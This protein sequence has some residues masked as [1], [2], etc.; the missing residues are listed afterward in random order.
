[1]AQNVYT[2]RQRAQ[3]FL[4]NNIDTILSR[5]GRNSQFPGETS[6]TPVTPIGPPS[7]AITR[8]VGDDRTKLGTLKSATKNVVT[9]LP[10]AQTIVSSFSPSKYLDMFD[11]V[12]ADDLNDLTP[13]VTLYKVYPDDAHSQG[14][15]VELSTEWLKDAFE[16]TLYKV[17]LAEYKAGQRSATDWQKHFG[18]VGDLP[19]VGITG[20]TIKKLG[21]NPAE[22]DSNIQVSLTIET[23]NLNN[24]FYRYAPADLPGSPSEKVRDLIMKN[25]VAWIDL[26]KLNPSRANT[27]SKCEQVYN[28]DD[29]RIKLKI[30]Y[31]NTAASEDDGC[32][33]K[34]KAASLSDK[35]FLKELEERKQDPDLWNTTPGAIASDDLKDEAIKNAAGKT[36]DYCED[37]RKILNNH[38]ETFYL[39]LKNHDLVIDT[40]LSV[41]LTIDFIGYGEAAQRTGKADLLHNPIL[42]RK[43]EIVTGEIEAINRRL[44]NYPGKSMDQ[45]EAE[46]EEAN[47]SVPEEKAKEASA[48]DACKQKLEEEGKQL[49]E[50]FDRHLLDAKRMLYKQLRLPVGSAK[51]SRIYEVAIPKSDEIWY[52]PNPGMGS[53]ESW[54]NIKNY[55]DSW[56][57]RLDKAWKDDAKIQGMSDR[58][59]SNLIMDGVGKDLEEKLI[60]R[61]DKP[62]WKKY[63]GDKREEHL[64][65]LQEFGD[66]RFVQFVFFGDI[67]EAALEILTFN[68]KG[69][70]WPATPV[71][72]RF[73]EE[74]GEDGAVGPQAQS[75]IDTFG[76][77]IFGDIELRRPDLNAYWA[78]EEGIDKEAH[79]TKY[80]NIADIPVD[81]EIFRTFW[82][83]NVVSNTK[84]TKY[85]FKNLITGLV[86]QVLPSALVHRKNV[87]SNDTP[88]VNPEAILLNFSLS[89]D[90]A[91]LN[92]AG[93][94]PSIEDLPIG[95][96]QTVRQQ[97]EDLDKKYR[98][99]HNG[100]GMSDFRKELEMD[101]LTKKA[102]TRRGLHPHFP[103]LVQ[104]EV[105]KNISA[106]HEL[107][108]GKWN[109][110]TYEVFA[111]VQKSDS[112]IKRN[113]DPVE[114][115]KH[116]ITHFSL[117]SGDK[118]MLL[119][120]QFKR[121]DLPA[122]QVANLF[123]DQG[124]NKLGILREKYDASIHLRGNVAYKPGAV[125]YIDPD[126]MQ[127]TV[128]LPDIVQSK[129]G[130]K[131]TGLARDT[132]PPV[133]TG[134]IVSAA[135]TLGLGGYFVVISVDHDFGHLGEKPDWRTILNTKWLSFKHLGGLSNVCEKPDD[136]PAPDPRDEACIDQGG[137]PGSPPSSRPG[138]SPSAPAPAAAASGPPQPPST[139]TPHF[140]GGGWPGMP[141]GS[142][143]D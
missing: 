98:E 71:V 15:P 107:A 12:L 102:T 126:S 56:P 39:T 40:D 43:L 122:L 58:E 63:G 133:G 91:T 54:L 73:F 68:N 34:I 127:D 30:G 111:I 75:A 104:S 18:T 32:E 110:E 120:A 60:D 84:L 79:T 96:R 89:G 41:R 9:N 103:Y 48:R 81:L 70:V 35:Q 125:I 8:V 7:V 5:T 53:N 27:A 131:G 21:G 118:G 23:M 47:G 132:L 128:V 67:V 1:M 78:K 130:F 25:G 143:T 88:T 117:K 76:K 36:G 69:L 4:L 64:E 51:S 26:I 94:A 129:P 55:W 17:A 93:I 13:E 121:D 59:Q 137:P 138:S 44:G 19:K 140:P 74:L 22:V 97:L 65:K 115:K 80:I 10:D 99:D 3:S 50:K 57:A 42:S 52:I 77:F 20:C 62:K 11:S 135:R 113:A 83:T 134:K 16:S 37:K 49:Q 116:G 87:Y 139:P 82:S 46:A 90:N 61:S 28:E 14:Y 31:P 86:N 72:T 105:Y 95:S 142:A 119:N 108:T 109:P 141:G 6:K 92:S 124:V 112:Q 29:T 101:E 66:W 123:S 114:D 136:E 85:F 106:A 38:S 2:E 33:E 24:L 100:E 45:L